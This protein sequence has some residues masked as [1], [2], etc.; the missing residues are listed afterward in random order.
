MPTSPVTR[1]HVDALGRG[2]VKA[3]TGIAA[4]IAAVGRV[5]ARMVTQTWRVIDH[6]PAALRVLSVVGILMLLGIVGTIALPGTAGLLCAVVVVPL[7]SITVGA[8]GHRWFSTPPSEKAPRTD[9]PAPE[10]ATSDLARSVAYV[11]TKLTLALNAFGSDRH[12]QAVIALFQAKTAVE[13][14]LGTERDTDTR[15]DAPLPITDHPR[16][17]RIQAGSASLA[18]S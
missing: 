14:A 4:A 18:A 9:V 16:R 5:A 15:L 3:A 1:E 8:L 13:L 12:E 6:V 11:D 17:P 10:I 7:C 2:A